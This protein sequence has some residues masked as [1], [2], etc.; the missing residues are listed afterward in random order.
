MSRVLSEIRG[1]KRRLKA[2]DADDSRAR[3]NFER[4]YNIQPTMPPI[5]RRKVSRRSLKRRARRTSKKNAYTSSAK[6]NSTTIGYSRNKISPRAYRKHLWQST[7]FS[8]HWRSILTNEFNMAPSNIG[9]TAAIST[10][11][12]IG[13]AFWSAAGGFTGSGTFNDTGAFTVRGGMCKL[14]MHNDM[15]DPLIVTVYKMYFF[16][17]ADS[18]SFP[19]TPDSA[20]DPTYLANFSRDYKVL[21][22]REFNIREQDIVTLTHKI[23]PF[24]TTQDNWNAGNKKLFWCIK[25]YNP[26]GTTG[27]NLRCHVSHNLSFT[28]DHN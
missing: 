26:S 9:T 21:S 28:G 17:E 16:S 22:Q 24:R 27:G 25:A 10:P 8:E 12:I 6:G 11:N 13:D 14:M 3:A 23:R 15:S 5:K 2:Q 4:Y 1:I 20:W 19:A 7:L 18:G